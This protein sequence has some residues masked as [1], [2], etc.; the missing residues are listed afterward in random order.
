MSNETPYVSQMRVDA[1]AFRETRLEP[2]GG[3]D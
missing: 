1:S 3:D 2:M